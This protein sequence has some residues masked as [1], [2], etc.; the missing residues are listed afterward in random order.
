MNQN[1]VFALLALAAIIVI[2]SIRPDILAWI[3]VLLGIC[4]IVFDKQNDNRQNM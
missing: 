2:G 4:T 3:M 1:S